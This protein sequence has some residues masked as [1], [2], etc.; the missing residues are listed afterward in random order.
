MSNPVYCRLT[1]Y[2]A[3]MEA[4]IILLLIAVLIILVSFKSS[5]NSRID[6]L[7]LEI[8]NLQ[9]IIK[10]NAEQATKNIGEERVVRE[11]PSQE[12][13]EKPAVAK[14]EPIPQPEVETPVEPR[15]DAP[16]PAP[17]M[18]EQQPALPEPKPVQPVMPKV[19]PPVQPPLPPRPGFFERNPDLEKF[20]GEN[21]VSKIGIAILVIA[22]GF[23]VKFAI[24]NEWIGP[25]GRV[26][27][28]LLCGGILTGL[29]H[30]LH[31][32]YKAFSSVLIGGGLAIFYFSI[33]LAYKDYALFGQTAA[34]MI[35][36]VITLFAVI[37]SL[38]YDRQE[39][40]VI[41]LVGGFC[42]PF[43]VSDGSGNY[44]T[45]FIYLLMLNAGLL[46]IAYRKSW[47]LLNLLAFLFTV[48]LFGGWMGTLPYPS[49][50]ATYRNGLLFAT[51]FYLLFLAI[52]VAH[53]V[54]QQKPFIASDFGIILATTAL[55]FG[56]GL[57]LIYSM[58]QTYYIGLF[59]GALGA[60]NLLLC[61][62]LFRN[63]NVD[64]N[65]L[66]LLIGIT[67]TFISLTIPLQLNGHYITL[68]WASE[69]VLLYW[70][71]Q[72]SKISLTRITALIIWGC[73]LVSLF[74]DW[75]YVYGNSPVLLT[76][77]LNKGFITSLYAA[78]ATIAL[79]LLR[80]KELL[81]G[82]EPPYSVPAPVFLVA[83]ILLLYMAGYLELGYQLDSRYPGGQVSVLY[84]LGY[85]FA[86]ILSLHLLVKRKQL[87]GVAVTA[88]QVLL[89][90][91]VLVYVI[92]L[93][94]VFNAQ[95]TFLLSGKSGGHFGMHWLGAILLGI[96]FYQLLQALR[97]R[98]QVMEQ[99]GT[100]V[101][102]VGCALIVLFVS[103]ELHLLMYQLFYR[104]PASLEVVHRV[105]IKAG[106]P[107]I[108]GLCSFVFMWLGM[109]HKYRP[110]RIVSLTLFLITLLKL[111][112][113]DIRNIPVGGKIAA[114]FCLGVL[115]LVVSFMYQRL[116]KIIVADEPENKE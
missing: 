111:F 94:A 11:A 92:T 89:G 67:I 73:M 76:V 38:L 16:I 54:K 17:V 49:P 56:A 78:A 31:T 14:Q 108:W 18:P 12:R 32:S 96:I 2:V 87:T 75:S 51:L 13:W 44:I 100:L 77:V 55:Y 57:G 61:F 74:M 90:L 95:Q 50:M 35:M 28:G 40:A 64:K 10:K 22:I 59:S 60:F 23:F 1:R 115:L 36:V 93:P 105:F 42:V 29:A 21:L 88:A 63:K 106:L 24:D 84:L 109:K 34:F 26:A 45:L 52:N 48:I 20:I 41:A 116:K 81:A 25:V 65:V 66:Y 86:F 37:L 30:R 68:F 7:Q 79:Y 80:R 91:A 82:E 85:T 43:I 58:N 69:A 97:S 112:I 9:L 4:L 101:T 110:L 27:I 33:A 46:A 113:F 8:R 62:L 102:W 70:L 5:I 19:V 3:S 53:N 39:V 47:R 83:G 99:M 6:R 15:P 72:K 71:Y 98:E 103:A 107:I 114:F 104:N